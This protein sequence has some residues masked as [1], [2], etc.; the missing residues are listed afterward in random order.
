[1]E[2]EDFLK[3]VGENIKKLRTEK[4]LSQAELARRCDKE[5]ASIER[6]ENGKINSSAYVLYEVA[7]GGDL[8][9][10]SFFEDL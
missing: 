4:G 6:I 5:R 10:K 9:L 1:M 2:K 7:K 8:D 3:K